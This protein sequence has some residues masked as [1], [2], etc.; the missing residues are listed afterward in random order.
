[1]TAPDDIAAAALR[2]ARDSG[3]DVGTLSLTDIA[4]AAG[5]SRS[6]LLRRVG[7][8]AALD[9]A[10]RDL[11]AGPLTLAGRAVAA[12]GR[13]IAA[14]GVAALTLERV[15]ADAGCTVMSIYNQI[16]NRDALLV[17]VFERHA[18][19]PRFAP[20]LDGNASLTEVAAE[21]Y[22]RLLEVGLDE[23]SVA[24]ALMVDAVARPGSALAAHIR[25]TYLPRSTTAVGELLS[26]QISAE[27]LVELPREALLA[28]FLGPVQFY[29]EV[30]TLDRR[31]RSTE[32]RAAVAA[33]LADAFA[34]AMTPSPRRTEP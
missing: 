27:V 24:T 31:P 11:G 18:V 28:Q 8:R 19:L 5:I 13:V 25:E 21:V 22:R 33:A 2:V 1:M 3:R 20:L 4:A 10:L 30:A 12:A 7:G 32:E 6:T 15:A 26:A 14:D 16:G 9:A 23:S 34:R 17:A 29:L